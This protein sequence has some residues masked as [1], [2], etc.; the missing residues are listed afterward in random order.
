MKMIDV[1]GF[2][3]YLVFKQSFDSPCIKETI[4][5]I[6]DCVL[7]QFTGLKDKNGVDVYEGDIAVFSGIVC[8]IKWNDNFCGFTL[9]GNDKTISYWSVKDCNVIGNIYENPQLLSTPTAVL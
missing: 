3:E 9:N 4:F 1:F 8:E 2:N 5:E 7:L 6:E